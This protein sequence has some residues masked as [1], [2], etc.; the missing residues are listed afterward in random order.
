MGEL[1]EVGGDGEME[2][3]V[4]GEM[5]GGVEVVVDCERGGGVRQKG[6]VDCTV[7]NFSKALRSFLGVR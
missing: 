7:T 6:T 4:T 2:G 3:V 1:E 5:E